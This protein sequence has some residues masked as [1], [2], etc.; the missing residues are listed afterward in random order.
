M[1]DY[2]FFLVRCRNSGAF[3]NIVKQFNI[4]FG[5]NMGQIF[6]TRHGL[7]KLLFFISLSIL[8]YIPASFAQNSPQ[9]PGPIPE[10]KQATW[11]IERPNIEKDAQPEVQS[12]FKRG[13]AFRIIVSPDT[14]H[15]L[16][17]IYQ[18]DDNGEALLPIVGKVKVDTWSEK[19]LTA[20][21]DSL[22]LPYLRF[23]DINVQPLMRVAMLGGFSK[24]GLYYLSPTSSLWDALA[25]AGGTI[26]EDGL[27]KIKWERGNALVKE[28]LL[29]DIE[30]GTSL[31]GIGIRSGDQLCVTHEPKREGWEIF[32][33]DILPMLTISITA[34][35]AFATMYF[36]YQTYAGRR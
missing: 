22:Y 23:P 26:R 15:F 24:P 1:V 34:A 21:L 13:D 35:S 36:S 12:P 17:G 9:A 31:S 14:V 19:K 33:T 20:Y 7:R 8:S 4:L 18:I 27:K 10:Q 16:V 28:N 29:F 32:R 11:G 5:N 3:V 25:Q 30:A 2:L 6:H